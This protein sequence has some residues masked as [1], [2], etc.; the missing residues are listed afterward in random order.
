[1]S[2]LYEVLKK[3]MTGKE[4][5]RSFETRYTGDDLV[6]YISLDSENKS[7]SKVYI[8]FN[9]EVD[10]LNILGVEDD[11][12][13]WTWKR[14]NHYYNDSDIDYYRY[15]EDFKE[16]YTLDYFNDENKSKIR[17]ILLYVQPSLMDGE[18]EKITK[19]LMTA[20]P[21]EVD[22]IIYEYAYRDQECIQRE[23]KNI[24]DNETKD[25]FIKFGIKERINGYKYVTTVGILYHWYRLLK[26]PDLDLKELLTLML[27]KYA[28]LD[29]GGWYELEY[30]V[31]CNDFDN[32]GFQRDVSS[33]LDNIIDNLEDDDKYSNVE[34]YRE[35]I[36]KVNELGGF[37]KIL[38]TPKD[39]NIRYKISKIDTVTNK[40]HLK[41][42]Y[43]VD[44]PDY[45][46]TMKS[47]TKERS[48]DLEELNLF[49]YHPE[50]F[51]ESRIIIDR[52]F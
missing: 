10:F 23:V 40:V 5:I 50:L 17:N 25:P 44:H 15:E 21:K 11:D 30:N 2:D 48:V 42:I 45:D 9:E 1:M 22:E 41:V 52:F 16:G 49:L 51:K 27:K 13:I 26:R 37:D 7:S 39:N 36:N 24:I 14:F 18:N 46:G 29:V 8:E 35:L 47:I 20:F 32:E 6:D 3:I 28:K 43:G 4:Y 33:I 31:Y 19:F 12:D 34:E 38:R